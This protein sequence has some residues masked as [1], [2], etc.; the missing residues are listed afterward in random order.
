MKIKFSEA[1]TQGI[2]G[3]VCILA[4][5]ASYLAG[6]W[7]IF[8]LIH[9]F[10]WLLALTSFNY[11][12]AH[13]QDLSGANVFNLF[14]NAY[15]GF[16]TA[17]LCLIALYV[18][19]ENFL[20]VIF[21][22]LLPLVAFA[23][24][25][26]WIAVIFKLSRALNRVLF[27]VYGWTFAVNVA[28]NAAYYALEAAWP[29]LILP[30]T[31]FKTPVAASLDLAASCILLAA[32]ISVG[33]FSNENKENLN[34]TGA[35]EPNFSTQHEQA[36]ELKFDADQS[37][38]NKIPPQKENT[39]EKSYEQ[40]TLK[41][42][43]RQGIISCRLML[44]NFA[45]SFLIAVYKAITQP[46][47]VEQLQN[48][49]LIDSVIT[50]LS[51]LT[52][53]VYMWLALKKLAE[54]YDTDVYEIFTK[55]VIVAVLMIFL[56]IMLSLKGITS[57]ISEIISYAFIGLIVYFFILWLKLNFGLAKI[58][59]N[60]LFKTYVFFVIVSAIVGATI[61]TLAMFGFFGG[62]IFV[63]AAALAIAAL[64]VLPTAFYLY[65]WTMIKDE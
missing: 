15:N 9:T 18:L 60:K 27:C 41:A 55:T 61:K 39:H 25:V 3:A 7:N 8:W 32:W 37:Q 65:A 40:E 5:N 13:T 2:I 63:L 1:K 19:D 26:S 35:N 59:K 21:Y 22:A 45:A 29:G 14:N 36:T 23:V 10:A 51:T 30:I 57:G 58:T 33:K 48:L 20:D 34:K 64:Y 49:E 62:G 42:A 24:A 12:L 17:I 44:A 11:A 56:S 6:N 16:L 46:Y 47:T 28:V 4:A 50:N 31:K 54:I 53:T 52:A 38:A 43:K